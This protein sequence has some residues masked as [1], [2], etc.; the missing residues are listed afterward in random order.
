MQHHVIPD[1]A[2]PSLENHCLQAM[3]NSNVGMGM[4][5]YRAGAYFYQKQKTFIL[6]MIIW[7][8]DHHQLMIM[9]LSGQSNENVQVEGGGSA[10]GRERD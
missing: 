2:T 5:W 10:A 4:G 1:E 9:Q 8:S 7:P 3:N 6:S